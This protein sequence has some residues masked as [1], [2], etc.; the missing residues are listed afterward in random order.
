VAK[1][2]WDDVAS[3]DDDDHSTR[4]RHPPTGEIA[5]RR[6]ASMLPW[7]LLALLG[8]GALTWLMRDLNDKAQARRELGAARD[9]AAD[10]RKQIFVAQ[11]LAA[12]AESARAQTAATAAQLQAKASTND[13]LIGELRAQLDA[14]EGDVSSDKGAIAVNLVDQIL[15]KSGEAAISPGGQKVLGKVGAVLKNV[16]DKQILIGGHTDDRPIHTA[17]FPSNWELSA[18]RAVNVVHYLSESAGVD[19]A[20]LTAAGYSE[21]HPRSKKEK[22]KNRR[23]EIL[24]TPTVEV[25]SK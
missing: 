13:K 21:F 9:E 22:A 17:Q 1:T 4:V 6:V 3:E 15:F 7:L 12:K 18:A 11:D 23:I 8:A 20:K 14:K 10:L 5:P 24:L 19:P 2:V 16:T 25:S